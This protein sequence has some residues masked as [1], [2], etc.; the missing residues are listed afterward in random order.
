M[1]TRAVSGACTSAVDERQRL[2][3][4]RMEGSDPVDAAD[5]QPACQ[6]LDGAHS[7]RRG[8]PASQLLSLSCSRHECLFCPYGACARSPV[9]PPER[10]RR[11][12]LR[13][14]RRT[15]QHCHRPGGRSRGPTGR[16]PPL[17]SCDRLHGCAP[18]R[19]RN[20]TVAAVGEA[21]RIARPASDVAQGKTDSW[22]ARALPFLQDAQGSSQ[23]PWCFEAPPKKAMQAR[24]DGCFRPFAVSMAWR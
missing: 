4:S 13:S 24:A 15:P 19:G 21:A 22:R 2:G 7:T 14:F 10:H 16:R 8:P 11:S 1:K 12:W 3:R 6:E 23:P 9:S 18:A 5:V 17:L 20:I